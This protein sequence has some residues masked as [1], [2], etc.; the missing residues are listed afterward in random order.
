MLGLDQIIPSLK[1]ESRL[2]KSDTE[3]ESSVS[4]LSTSYERLLEEGRELRL[5]FVDFTCFRH[6]FNSIYKLYVLHNATRN[7]HELVTLVNSVA[8]DVD[9]KRDSDLY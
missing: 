4:R 1:A 7:Y 2:K 9:C 6:Q 8:H 5:S 3:L